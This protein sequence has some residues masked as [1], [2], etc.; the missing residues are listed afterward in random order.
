MVG[1]TQRSLVAVTCWNPQN[2]KWYPLASLPFYDREFFSVVSA[3]D[4]IYL[5]GEA[6]R[7]GWARGMRFP[8]GFLHTS[9]LRKAKAKAQE[10]GLGR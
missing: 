9:G 10:R 1:M 2:H 3:G 7:A 4:N 5:S 6:L 8:G